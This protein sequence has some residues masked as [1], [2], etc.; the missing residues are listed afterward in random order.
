MWDRSMKVLFLNYEYPPLGGGAGNATFYIFKEFSK[1]PGLEIDCITSSLDEKYHLEKIGDTIRIHRLPIGKNK[2]NLHFQSQKD[3]LMYARKAYFF[4]RKLTKQSKKENKPYNLTHAFFSVPCGFMALLLKWEFGIS[5]IVSLRGADV[6]GYSE[7]FLVLYHILK[8]MVKLV[9]ARADSVI[10]NSQGLKTLA[11]SS[12]PDQEIGVIYNGI[13][14]REF[15]PKYNR[16]EHVFKILCLSR[17]TPR[18]GVTYLIDAVHKL[19]KKYPGIHPHT[20]FIQDDILNKNSLLS[21]KLSSTLS[22]GYEVGVGVKLKIVGEGDSKQQ[23]VDQVKNLSLEDNVEFTGLI[24][25]ENLAPIYRKAHA[26]V[27]PS[28][29]EGMSNVILEAIASGLPIVTT[30]T[31][32]SKELVRDGVNGFIVRMKDGDDIAEK[33]ERLITNPGLCSRMSKESR[34]IAEGLSWEKVAREYAEAYGKIIN[35]KTL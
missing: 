2:K 10:A 28:L 34:K 7:R 8:P 32:G 3:I 5:Y 4:S 27:L 20:N 21:N 22:T 24:R 12:K 6:P 14:I 23:L 26:F 1:I 25:H 30:D 33:L 15:Y 9:W 11:L 19:S 18:K 17:L 29:N 16:D 13:D 31:G 35:K